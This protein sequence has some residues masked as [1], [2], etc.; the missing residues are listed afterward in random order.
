MSAHLRQKIGR[1]FVS[2]WSRNAAQEKLTIAVVS[3]SFRNDMGCQ[4]NKLRSEYMKNL[5]VSS[6]LIV[7]MLCV[8][9]AAGCAKKPV[10]AVEIP[11]AAKQMSETQ[12]ATPV[13][14]SVAEPR[15]GVKA[16]I[17]TIE[18]DRIQFAFDQA[19]LSP[20]A[21]DALAANAIVLKTNPELKANIEGHC[22]NRGSDEYNLAL[23]ERRALAAREYLV[24]LGVSAERLQVISYGEERPADAANTETAWAKNRRAEFNKL[25]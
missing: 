16:E 14:Q 2:A 20:E 15:P 23:G 9:L 3:G 25:D 8:L 17:P 24:S 4:L 21:R 11:P 7:S 19:S 6:V 10:P 22:D 1:F 18:L 5:I 13:E 12:P